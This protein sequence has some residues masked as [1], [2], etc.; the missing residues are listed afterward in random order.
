M[1]KRPKVLILAIVTAIGTVL[2]TVLLIALLLRGAAPPHPDADV[3]HDAA[4]TAAARAKLAAI[5]KY[6]QEHPMPK[7]VTDEEIL[8][9]SRLVP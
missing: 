7:V 9:R 2:N 6:D 3:Q 1:N 4:A 8:K 5:V